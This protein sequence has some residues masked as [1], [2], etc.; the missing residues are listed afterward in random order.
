[1]NHGLSAES[2]EAVQAVLARFPAVARALLYG[3]RARGDFKPGSDIDL[4][5]CGDT[6]THEH[7][8]A[9]AW[10]LDDLLLPYTLD[11]TI[12]EHM[13]PV[14]RRQTIIQEGKLFYE[15]RQTKECPM[16]DIPA[17]TECARTTLPIGLPV[18]KEPP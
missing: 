13:A 14:Q 16:S 18:R 7:L 12:L 6:L 1:M 15:R 17:G 3:S 4:A 10:Q 9:I 11:L 2:V 8:T 5:L